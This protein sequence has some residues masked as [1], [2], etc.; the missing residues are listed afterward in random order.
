MSFKDL[1]KLEFAVNGDEHYMTF[2][3]LLTVLPESW[4]GKQARAH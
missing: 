4:F 3:D 1:Y 2:E